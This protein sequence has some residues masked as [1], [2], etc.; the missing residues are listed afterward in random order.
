MIK[1]FENKANAHLALVDENENF[2]STIKIG[3][4]TYE[5]PTVIDD[6]WEFYQWHRDPLDYLFQ[7]GQLSKSE[8]QVLV[9]KLSDTAIQF[10]IDAKAKAAKSEFIGRPIL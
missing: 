3:N 6:M 4:V 8:Y 7:K 9:S 1:A 2:E 5:C 10:E